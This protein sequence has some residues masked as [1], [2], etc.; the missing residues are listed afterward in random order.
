MSETLFSNYPRFDTDEA[1]AAPH[2]AGRWQRSLEADNEPVHEMP[3][4]AEPEFEAQPEVQPEAEPSPSE[5]DLTKIEASLAA[6]GARLDKIE[7]EANAQA[8]QA[9]QSMASKLFPELSRLFLAEE[10]SRHLASLVPAS[11]AVVDIRAEPELA[12]QLQAR[13]ESLPALAHRCTVTPVA[14]A[15][16]GRVDVAWKSGGASF[17]FDGLLTACLSHLSSTQSTTRD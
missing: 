5:I 13:V 4:F 14:S 2:A 16:Q 11:A 8:L 15:G 10:V 6:L 9:V 1:P 17:D 7:R 3:P 12:A